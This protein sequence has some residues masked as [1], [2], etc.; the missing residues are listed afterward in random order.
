MS[1]LDIEI[2]YKNSK[3]K[4]KLKKLNSKYSFLVSVSHEKD[5]AA[6]IVMSKLK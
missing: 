3:P 2:Y 6:A 5:Y 4:I 1:F